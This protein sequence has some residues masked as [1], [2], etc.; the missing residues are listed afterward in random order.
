MAVT[1]NYV[2]LSEFND[3]MTEYEQAQ[4][5]DDSFA[6]DGTIS[7]DEPSRDEP[8]VERFLKR[9]ESLAD[10]YLIHYDRPISSP[11]EKLKYAVMVIARYM[12]DDRGDGAVSEDIQRSHDQAID[13]LKDVR[14]G[15]VDLGASVEEAGEDFFGDRQGGTFGEAPYNDKASIASDNPF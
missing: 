12:L 3:V 10:S 4:A 2:S 6:Q 7:S 11:P 13:W 9:A 8:M 14:D 1:L 5:T 15:S